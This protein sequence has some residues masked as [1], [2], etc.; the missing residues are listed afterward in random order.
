[1][2]AKCNHAWQFVPPCERGWRNLPYRC[3]LCG[4]LSH[5]MGL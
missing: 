3:L 2:N 4:A 1:M 5:W